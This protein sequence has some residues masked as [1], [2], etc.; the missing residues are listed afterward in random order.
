[1]ITYK[2]KPIVDTNLHTITIHENVVSHNNKTNFIIIVS[3]LF[4][5]IISCFCISTWIIIKK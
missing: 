3:F 4:L 5:F 2:I 1:M